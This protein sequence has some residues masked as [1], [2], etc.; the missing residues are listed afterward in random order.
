MRNFQNPQICKS[1]LPTV[2]GIKKS[3]KK[4]P[5]METYFFRYFICHRIMPGLGENKI[6]ELG[7]KDIFSF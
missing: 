2:I 3:P 5:G 6:A 1:T 4:V 7:P